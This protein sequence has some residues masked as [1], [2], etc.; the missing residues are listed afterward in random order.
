MDE[1]GRSAAIVE[2]VPKLRRTNATPGIPFMRFKPGG[3]VLHALRADTVRTAQFL[4]IVP[5]LPCCL[6]RRAAC[7]YRW[8]VADVAGLSSP[9][10]FGGAES[11]SLIPGRTPK[12]F[13]R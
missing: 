6:F 5:T 13:V 12:A 11:T 7:G 2:V 3:C 1:D 8:V 10:V 9:K 4:D